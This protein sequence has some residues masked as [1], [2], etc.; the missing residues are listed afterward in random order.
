MDCEPAFDVEAAELGRRK[1]G[2]QSR[3]SEERIGRG[4]GK[5]RTGNA[6]R[7][8]SLLQPLQQIHNTLRLPIK[9]LHPI[10]I[11]LDLLLVLEIRHLRLAHA[12][13]E[14][15]SIGVE[16]GGGVEVGVGGFAEWADVALGV[17]FLWIVSSSNQFR[18]S[19]YERKGKDGRAETH[20]PQLDINRLLHLPHPPLDRVCRLRVVEKVVR[21]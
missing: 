14:E 8:L 7:Y 10:L 3:R 2:C 16:E 11:P 18:V 5:K 13:G 15:V 4:Q 17:E 20:V 21:P 19:R 9:P 6:P 12:A 1:G